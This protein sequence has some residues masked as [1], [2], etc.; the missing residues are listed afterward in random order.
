MRLKASPVAV[1]AGCPVTVRVNAFP[2]VLICLKPL[3]SLLLR[4]KESATGN[5]AVGGSWF[6]TESRTILMA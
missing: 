4:L 3:L 6:S 2:K 5:Y 1:S